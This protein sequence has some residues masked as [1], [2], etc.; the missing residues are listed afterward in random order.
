M[1]H[2]RFPW[3]RS[4]RRSSMWPPYS[5]RRSLSAA[6][7]RPCDRS[8]TVHTYPSV[9][10]PS[11][12]IPPHLAQQRCQL[13]R[14]PFVTLP[15]PPPHSTFSPTTLRV[16]TY[17]LHDV[18]ATHP[19]PLHTWPNNDASPYVP[20]SWRYRHTPTP[21]NI[22]PTTITVHTYPSV[23]LPSHHTPPHLAQQ[24]CQLIRS[25]FV[26]LPTPPP[27]STFVQTTLAVHTYPLHDVAATPPHPLHTWPNYDASPYVPPSWRYR[28]T[29]TPL[30]IGPTTITVHTYPSVTLPSHHTPPHLAQ[31]WCQLIRSPFVTLPT[32]PP[33]ST[34]GPT[35]MSVHT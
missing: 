16:Q 35:T 31:Q 34:F 12:H 10:L 7:C 18:A 30:N 29:P 2:N 9:T 23:T 21:L 3:K 26:T 19:H 28:H 4:G 20:P 27:H 6:A 22:G 32:P 1:L 5:L 15:T 13:I 17:S 24:R 8:L 33:H 14:S 11:H 25:P